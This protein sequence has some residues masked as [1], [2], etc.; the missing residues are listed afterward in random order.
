M[1]DDFVLIRANHVS[2]DPSSAS[3]IL[4]LI[5][6]PVG[7]SPY[8]GRLTLSHV[9]MPLGHA[10]DTKVRPLPISP[11]SSTEIVLPATCL[12]VAIRLNDFMM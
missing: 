7:D 9:L 4:G 11:S 8:S 10:I 12:S 5:L 2:F 3:K 1:Y 6:T